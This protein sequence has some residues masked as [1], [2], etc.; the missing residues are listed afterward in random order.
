MINF[1]RKTRKKL[2]DDNKPFKYMRYAI[3]EIVLVV[4]GIL[5][6]LQINNWNEDRFT[7]ITVNRY[8]SSLVNELKDDQKNLILVQQIHSWRVHSLIYLLNHSG[9]Q[10]ISFGP[11]KMK[12]VPFEPGPG[13]PGINWKGPVPEIYD[14]EFI[15]QAFIWSG[16]F[17]SM[18]VSTGSIDELK[19]TG[20][21]SNIRD[22]GL[23]MD[24]DHYYS[25]ME[26]VFFDGI[27][28]ES[29]SKWNY[30]LLDAGVFYLQIAD[31]PNPLDL[32]ANSPQRAAYLKN[33]IAEA[34]YRS[35]MAGEYSSVI[36]SL[37][38]RIE[39]EIKD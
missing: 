10:S 22:P 5:I 33:I 20:M 31:L 32:I 36:D 23:K 17:M 16:R 29:V 19:N 14:L 25:N 12:I 21:F 35:Q 39:A 2:A 9:Q 1:F 30:S 3:G 28:E 27:H 34:N 13:I 26:W 18:K 7:R 38:F 11:Q 24:L 4:I 6:A 15:E 37:I 8:L